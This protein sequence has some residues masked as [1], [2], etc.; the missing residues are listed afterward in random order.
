MLLFD[1]PRWE[2]LNFPVSLR[3][4]QKII[5][6]EALSLPNMKSI[7]REDS[8]RVLDIVSSGYFLLPHE[9]IFRDLHEVVGTLGFPITEVITRV[10]NRGGYA[11]VEWCFNRYNSVTNSDLIQLTLIARNSID[12]SAQLQIELAGRVAV[13][14]NQLRGPTPNFK[15]SWKH[16]S[17]DQAE[18]LKELA[19]LISREKQMVAHWRPGADILIYVQR[20]RELLET[21]T[22]R[23]PLGQKAREKILQTFG[24]RTKIS[25]WEAYNALASHASHHTVTRRSDLLPVRQEQFHAFAVRLASHLEKP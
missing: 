9:Q 11:S 3:P 17:V 19:S 12:R 7:Y 5:G 10:G 18:V 4:V 22:T 2:L 16:R 15:R 23:A 13:S 14:Q 1:E 20:F 21:H 25:V 6:E 24:A 8:R